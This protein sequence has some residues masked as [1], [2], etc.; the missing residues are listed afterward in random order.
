MKF[1][2]ALKYRPSKR[3][4]GLAAVAALSAVALVGCSAGNTSDSSDSSGSSEGQTYTLDYATYNPQSGFTAVTFQMWAD[5]VEEATDGR[6]KFNMHY[7]GSLLAA[8]DILKGVADGRADLGYVASVYSTAE[9]PLSQLASVPFTSGS[10]YDSTVAF[11]ELYAI[12][13]DLQEEYHRNGVH[14]LT[15]VPLSPNIVIGHEKLDTVDSLANKRIRSAGSFDYALQA[16]GAIPTSVGGGADV[17][18]AFERGTIDAATVWPID[19]A[20]DQGFADIAK[21]FV[22]TG[23]GPTAL[24]ANVINL[25]V[26]NSLP[27]DIREAIESVNAT[28]I[29]RQFETLYEWTTTRCETAKESGVT[30][31]QF[32]KSEVEKWQGLL[33]DEALNAWKSGVTQADADAFLTD[34]EAIVAGVEDFDDGVQGCLS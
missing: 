23:T 8:P 25:E 3:G 7:A 2:D 31:S 24:T 26:W 34:Y 33:G 13:E 1:L 10:Y 9:L 32:S 5:A 27:E 30:I 17:Y 20:V 15:F 19:A 11:T 6:V 12:N 14:A 28:D 16:V 22:F 4:A 18:E 21:D 29:A